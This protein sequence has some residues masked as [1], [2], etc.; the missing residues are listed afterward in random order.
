MTVAKYTPVNIEHGPLRCTRCWQGIAESE[1]N[2]ES[3]RFKLVHDPGYWGNPS[4]S[5]LVLG[6]TKGFTQ[7]DAMK[8]ERDFDGVAF[9]KCRPNLLAVLKKLG[10]CKQ[11]SVENFNRRFSASER[12]FGFA[13]ALRCSLTGKTK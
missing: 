2:T 11:D 13:S 9:K 8:N 4:P 3:G 6:I 7:S 12:E 1:Q 10:L 5:K